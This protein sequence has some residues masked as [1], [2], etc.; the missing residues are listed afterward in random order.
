M[1]SGALQGRIALVTGG[2]QGNGKAIATGMAAA[3]ATVVIA[4][5][6]ARTAESAAAEISR[7]GQ[8]A[9]AFA[10]DISDRTACHAL[11]Q[12]IHKE[13]GQIS[14]LVNNAGI[15]LRSSMSEA[16]NETNWDRTVSV[17]I[18]GP[19]NVASAFLPHLR[20]TKGCIVNIGSIQSFVAA[21]NSAAYSASKGAVLQLTK[22]L[23][24]ELAPH[25][26]RVNGI[27]PGIIATAMSEVTR[28]DETKLEGFLRHVPMARVGQ[29]EE[30]AG[31]AVFLASDHASYITG[32]M[33]PVDGGYL[34]M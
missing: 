17:N 13:V 14:I 6:N 11:A 22:A 34:T 5:M 3:G 18:T 26:I 32:A 10:L 28:A 20:D 8:K 2:G 12:R 24:A 15:L 1:F 31:A 21:P 25:G 9:S 30:L 23:A 27:A 4:D 7:S 19:F 16:T 33:L 29:P